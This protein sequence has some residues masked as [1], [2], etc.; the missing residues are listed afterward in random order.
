[1]KLV[2]P[3]GLSGFESIIPK[4]VPS[5]RPQQEV[6]LSRETKT[7]LREIIMGIITSQSSLDDLKKAFSSKETAF[8]AFKLLDS[9]NKGYLT[10]L[11]FH[12]FFRKMTK[13]VPYSH[14]ELLFY[15]FNI[16]PNGTLTPECFAEDFLP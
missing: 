1:M 2:Q 16:A 13:N 10:T 15:H 12:D 14:L 11:D 7:L 3:G 5:K 6:S 4:F 8:S 9:K